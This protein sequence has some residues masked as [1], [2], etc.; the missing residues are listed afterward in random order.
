MKMHTIFETLCITLFL[1]RIEG[2]REYIAFS[3][4]AFSQIGVDL[5]RII[6][7]LENRV[8]TRILFLDIEP[9]DIFSLVGRNI[10]FWLE[11]DAIL[12]VLVIARARQVFF[13]C[14]CFYFLLLQLIALLLDNTT[15]LIANLLSNAYCFK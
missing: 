9:F 5:L 14:K 12:F 6:I 4:I 10:L 15:I 1:R 11:V 2:K 3:F 7:M 13:V 8:K